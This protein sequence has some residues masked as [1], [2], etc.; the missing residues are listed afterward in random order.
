ML[1]EDNSM[2]RILV[3]LAVLLMLYCAAGAENEFITMPPFVPTP[4]PAPMGIPTATPAAV[5]TPSII[6][7][8]DST[9]IP[10]QLQSEAFISMFGMPEQIMTT[11]GRALRYSGMDMQKLI[12]FL[13]LL[14]TNDLPTIQYDVPSG[15]LF[16]LCGGDQAQN[17]G[18]HTENEKQL[19]S[20]ALKECTNAISQIQ[21]C[22]RSGD[23]NAALA[24]ESIHASIQAISTLS[25]VSRALYHNELIHAADFDQLYQTLD[26]LSAKMANGSDTLEELNTLSSLLTQLQSTLQA[27]QN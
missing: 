15:A 16:L 22:P 3:A 4:T 17:S 20:L 11:Q 21:A 1:E 24:L 26:R 6:S 25:D 5:T 14:D 18:S 9:S 13:A 10:A 2:N 8:K 23:H 27:L 7:G 12:G 19:V